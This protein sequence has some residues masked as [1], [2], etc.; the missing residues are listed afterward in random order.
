[1]IILGIG[2][3]HE[4]H[5]C[6]VIDGKLISAIAEE[7]LS[8]LKADM[9][10][11]R[12]AIDKVL[13]IS[14]LGPKDIDIVAFAGESGYLF[15][16]IANY[17]A[18]FSVED[19]VKQCHLYWKP[20]L[21]EG[22]NLSF[23]DDFEMFKDRNP[24][25]LEDPYFS[26]IEK[27]KASHPSQWDK[28]GQEVRAKTLVD[29]LGIRRD[30]ILFYR[31]EDCHKAWGYFSMQKR[32]ERA[33]VLT[34]EGGGDDSSAT[35]STVE[36]KCKINEHWRSNEVM[37]GR[38]YRY[39]TLLLG[40]KPG[41]HEYKVMGLAPYGSEFQGRKSLEFFRKI[42]SFKGQEIINNKVL[43]DMYFSVKDALEG[44][45]FDGIAWGL[46][47]WL[48]EFLSIWVKNSVEF[49]K[50]DK[51]VLSGGVAQNIKACKTISE[52][53]EVS[54]FWAGPISGD[55]SLGL[56]AAFL[57]ASQHGKKIEISDIEDIY[58]GS[59]Y[60][61]SEIATAMQNSDIDWNKNYVFENP[62]AVDIARWISEGNIIARFSE[63]M[64]FGQRA[65]G[66]RSIL[67]DPRYE[68][69]I[70]RINRKIKKR[71]F[72]MPFTPSMTIEEAEKI[73]INP[74]K[75]YSPFMTMAFDLKEKF[76]NSIP[77]AIHPSDKSVRPQMLKR[78][79]N[80]EYYDVLDAFKDISG[81]GVLLNTSF[82][83]H[84]E[85]IVESPHDAISTFQR[86]D[87]DILIIGD[88]AIIRKK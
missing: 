81:L 9:G 21:L 62:S 28:I 17:N 76:L 27:A 35:I 14:G 68:N 88:K 53:P 36:S 8:R 19:W 63:K 3:S 70:Q 60:S 82:N 72:W 43:R 59:H 69:S 80:P 86:S 5:A 77:A 32:E 56:G 83:L 65:L 31:H 12:R 11:P 61:N 75:I 50:L 7:R 33:L 18:V 42:H 38:L 85:A 79:N 41:Q 24:N 87:I 67:A 54:N 20:K 4:A 6:I 52:L 39:V 34:L 71:D 2:D 25:L 40:M 10:Y 22:K 46:Q 47:T 55:G 15:Q 44:E 37:A 48:E 45:R 73:L 49:H 64:E 78:K 13:K 23:L 57:A 84:G 1:M 66:N 74:K 51:V 16:S 26:F 58:L 30:Q 29:H